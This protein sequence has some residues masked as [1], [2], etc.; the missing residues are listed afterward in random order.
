MGIEVPSKVKDRLVRYGT[1]RLAVSEAFAL[2]AKRFGRDNNL[3]AEGGKIKD[4]FNHE[5]ESIIPL[6]GEVQMEAPLVWRNRRGRG[7][8]EGEQDGKGGATR[9]LKED[10][11]LGVED[12]LSGL[13]QNIVEE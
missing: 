6:A 12:E 2:G 11:I 1:Y 4:L 10:D 7:A 8:G 3:V 13:A 5:G 9:H